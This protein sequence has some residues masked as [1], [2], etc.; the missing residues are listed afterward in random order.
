MAKVRVHTE[1]IDGKTYHTKTFPATEGL[2]IL[3]K[4]MA[5]LGDSVVSLIFGVEGDQ[6]D[7]LFADPKI[8][9]A[10]IVDVAKRAAD[11][12]GFL[13]LRD[14]LKY[15]ECDQCDIGGDAPI[16]GSV[17]EWFDRHFEGDYLHLLNVCVWVAR[18]SFAKP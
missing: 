18:V 12:D 9:G 11:N 8:V 14:L 17:Y 10:V 7:K 16:K 2:V 3:P 5:L 15:T 4:L 13:V 6:L 1:M